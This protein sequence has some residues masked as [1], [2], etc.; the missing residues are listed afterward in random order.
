MCALHHVAVFFGHGIAALDFSNLQIL[1]VAEQHVIGPYGELAFP[2]DAECFRHV[3]AVGA[4]AHVVNHLEE[5]PLH[6]DDALFSKCAHAP[7]VA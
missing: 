4:A 6:R 2:H 1:V 7:V 3:L 5:I